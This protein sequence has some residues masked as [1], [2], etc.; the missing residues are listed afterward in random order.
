[1]GARSHLCLDTPL[2]VSKEKSEDGSFKYPPFFYLDTSIDSLSTY[3]YRIASVDYFG[4]AGSFSN[5]YSL[6]P[7]DF[8][9]PPT[10]ENVTVEADDRNLE[11]TVRWEYPSP[12]EDLAGFQIYIRSDADEP[13]LAALP[14]IIDPKSRMAT[15][16]CGENR[17]L[18]AHIDSRRLV[19]KQ[20]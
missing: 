1:M 3:T 8:N 17:Q 18:S 16:Q 7:I 14:E 19:R 15:L 6:A 12:P 2:Y 13:P 20:I 5:E 9:F 10:P 11:I 4:Q